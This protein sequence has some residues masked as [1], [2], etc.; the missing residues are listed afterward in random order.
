M[1]CWCEKTLSKCRACSVSIN[2]SKL[3]R[4]ERNFVDYYFECAEKNNIDLWLFTEALKIE[5]KYSQEDI[6]EFYI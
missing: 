3:T 4:Q 1:T 5:N 6:S 2:R